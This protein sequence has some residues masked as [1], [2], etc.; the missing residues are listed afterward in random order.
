[1]PEKSKLTPYLRRRL[2][3]LGDMRMRLVN[4]LDPPEGYGGSRPNEFGMGAAWE[5]A[6]VRAS[7]AERRVGDA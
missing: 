3:D 5:P 4:R 6:Y 1:Y 7:S 2:R